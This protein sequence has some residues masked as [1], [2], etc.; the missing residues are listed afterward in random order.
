[1]N[2]CLR[3]IARHLFE[4]EAGCTHKLSNMCGVNRQWRTAVVVYMCQ[5]PKVL[6]S[7]ELFT[8]MIEARTIVLATSTLLLRSMIERATNEQAVSAY[9][10]AIRASRLWAK[11][12]EAT[13][14]YSHLLRSDGDWRAVQD[15]KEGH[16]DAEQEAHKATTQVRD[17]E[18]FHMLHVL[19]CCE[20]TLMQ[21]N[22]DK[23]ESIKRLE[24]ASSEFQVAKLQDR[25]LDA[26]YE[27]AKKRARGKEVGE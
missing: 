27:R 25:T 16:R 15:A 21:H 24:K 1:M 10:L 23:A 17:I 14:L 8:A 20:R 18:P 7:L 6:D 22:L 12:E 13:A 19:S 9:F 4:L 3:R 5:E 11:A 2:E 26:S